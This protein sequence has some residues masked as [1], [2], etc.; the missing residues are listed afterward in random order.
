MCY[1]RVFWVCHPP[2]QHPRGYKSYKD[3]ISWRRLEAPKPYFDEDGY[4]T[5]PWLWLCTRRIYPGLVNVPQPIN[6]LPLHAHIE[7]LALLTTIRYP[8]FDEL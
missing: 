5:A 8:S 6:P 2:M 4:Y 1:E 7:R 3:F